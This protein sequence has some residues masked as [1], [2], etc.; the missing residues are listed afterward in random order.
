MGEQKNEMI[1]RRRMLLAG[2]SGSVLSAAWLMGILRPVLAAVSAEPSVSRDQALQQLLDGNQRYVRNDAKH[3]D[4]RP[5]A[6]DQHP[7]AALLSCSDSRVP[8]EII[9]DQGVGSIF[10]TRVAGN[11]YNNLVLES[12]A[13][14][15]TNLGVRLIVVMGHDQC[16]AVKAAIKEYPE[17][18]AGVMLKNIYP[19]VREA[20]GMRGDLL[21]NAI[22]A[23]AEL[24][25]KKLAAEAP[26]EPLIESGQLKIIAARYAL[27]SGR[28]TLLPDAGSA[29][30]KDV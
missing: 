18:L 23:N 6:D 22:N 15:I 24:M 11:T 10:V 25:A 21:S 16:G 4:Q 19:A 1:G 14:A 26:F 12:L 30:D 7:I 29:G 2:I 17:R 27:A 13:Y 3:P 28:V 9:F 20:K 8:P 5:T